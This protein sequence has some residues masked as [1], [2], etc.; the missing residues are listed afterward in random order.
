M[1]QRDWI[2]KDFYRELGIASGA[3]Q[4]EIKKAYRKLARELHPDKNPGDGKAEA[5]FKDVSEAYDVLS[6]E[7]RRREYDE[8]R[9][10]FGSGGIPGGFRSVQARDVLEKKPDFMI[11]K[12][13]WGM[14]PKNTLG[15]QLL[16]KLKVY[17]GA[18]HPHTAQQPQ[19][20]ALIEKK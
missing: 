7:P 8:A 5:R 19:P 13:V 20:M 12:A 16:T 15:R 6:D 2:E 11:R 4:D 10:L 17:A 9:S 14:L 18:D 1:T 3:S